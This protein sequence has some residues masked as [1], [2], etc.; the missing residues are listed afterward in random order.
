MKLVKLSPVYSRRQ[1]LWGVVYPDG[2]GT[3]E[4]CRPFG[5]TTSRF[6]TELQNINDRTD[7]LFRKYNDAVRFKKLAES[8]PNKHLLNGPLRIVKFAMQ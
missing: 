6:Y 8:S 1:C 7:G 3:Y 5:I 2:H 4:L